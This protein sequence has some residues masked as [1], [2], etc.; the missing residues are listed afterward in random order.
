MDVIRGVIFDMDGVLCDSEPFIC[1]AAGMMFAERYHVD[2]RA[3]DFIPFVGAGENRYIGGVAEKHGIALDLEADKRRTYEIYLRIIRGRLKPLPGV[4]GF[5]AACRKAGLKLAVATAADKVKLDGNLGQI[6]LPAEL[7]DATVHGNE[8]ARKKPDPEAFLLAARRLGLGAG[9][10]LVVE[11]APNGIRAAKT[12][13]FACLGLTSSFEA[14]TL[15]SA[16]ADW[17]AG[18]LAHVPEE[19]LALVGLDS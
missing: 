6:G 3:E 17:V 18:D 11:D 4:R 7:F 2:V 19:V 14:A 5:L 16:G 12:G 8:I 1:Q 9:Q 10:C 15:T 13:G